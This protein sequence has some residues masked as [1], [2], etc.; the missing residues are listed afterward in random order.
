M[1]AIEK[2]VVGVTV[3]IACLILLYNFHDDPFGAILL[4]LLSMPTF[5]W[6]ITVYVEMGFGDK[7]HRQMSG[8]GRKRK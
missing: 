8:S 3:V 1:D 4:S 6:V 2:V 7:A 5:W